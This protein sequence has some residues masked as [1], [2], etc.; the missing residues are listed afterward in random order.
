MPITNNS[1]HL[2]KRLFLRLYE[3][4]YYKIVIYFRI[5]YNVLGGEADL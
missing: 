1:Y 2:H 3:E 5:R 4:I